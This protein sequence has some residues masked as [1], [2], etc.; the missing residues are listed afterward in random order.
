MRI[1][2]EISGVGIV[3]LGSF[4]PAIFTPAWFALHG[5]LPKSVADSADLKRVSRI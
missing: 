1:D 5:L 3:V 2:P 4:N